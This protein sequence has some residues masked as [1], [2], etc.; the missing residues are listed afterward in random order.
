[1]ASPLFLR[2]LVNNQNGLESNTVKCRESWVDKLDSL[3]RI[4]CF[5]RPIKPYIQL[6]T[7]V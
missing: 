5:L 4:C 6:N 1:M 3:K 7:N 2:Y